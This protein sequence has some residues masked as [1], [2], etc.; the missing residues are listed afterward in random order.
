MRDARMHLL[1]TGSLADAY[2]FVA[3]SRQGQNGVRDTPESSSKSCWLALGK[4]RVF[5]PLRRAAMVFS[6]T[7]P[8][9]KTLPVSVT[10]PV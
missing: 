3:P 9:G 4:I 1:S 6:L 8:I 10:S 7:P 2:S 5:T